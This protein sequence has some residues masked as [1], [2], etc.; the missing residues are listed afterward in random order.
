MV[1][2]GIMA[3]LFGAVMPLVWAWMIPA[4]RARAR[5]R[6]LELEGEGEGDPVLAAEVDQL[7]MRLAEMEER[8]DF[9][10]RLL[11]KPGEPSHLER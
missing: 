11:A 8:L 10:E 5:A 3:V 4:I 9:A 7:R 6:R 1:F 2:T